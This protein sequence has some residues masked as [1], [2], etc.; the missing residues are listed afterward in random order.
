MEWRAQAV[1]KGNKKR[2]VR[3]NVRTPGQSAKEYLSD[4]MMEEAML[5]AI[6]AVM[7]VVWAGWEW[8][9]Y[10]AEINP[11]LGSACG[12][13]TV[14][15]GACVIGFRQV[16]RAREDMRRHRLGAEGEIA[17]AQHLEKLR[18]RRYRA[19]HDLPAD[20]FNVDHVLVGPTG[21]YAIE[22][23]TRMK[24]EGDA[25]VTYDGTKV[26]VDGYEPDRDPVA[27]AE[28]EARWVRELIEKL[29]GKR[30]YVQAVVLYPGWYVEEAPPNAGANVW[31]LNPKRLQTYLAAE[32]RTLKEEDIRQIALRFADY[33]EECSAGA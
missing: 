10:V 7:A 5:P 13:T 11:T 31:V 4:A 16:N 6:V 32:S 23:K 25:R 14:A 30:L 33:V 20:G 12:V 9:R 18:E 19:V 3:Q 22:T 27:Q 1:A 28:A 26:R 21:V 2:P 17:V 24:P 15:I 8:L 29:T